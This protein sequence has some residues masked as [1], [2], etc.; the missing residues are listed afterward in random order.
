MK[1]SAKRKR[2][3][4]LEKRR[5]LRLTGRI[6]AFLRRDRSW[7]FH[8]TNLR[9]DSRTRK[10][11][12]ERDCLQGYIIYEWKVVLLDYEADLPTMAHEMFHLFFRNKTEKEV[13]RLERM[14]LRHLTTENALAIVKLVAGR[15]TPA[16]M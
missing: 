11:M 4:Q 5:A 2:E 3:R 12:K 10:L 7:K 13:R 15:L 14:F 9:K 6:I 16:P 8:Y 1:R